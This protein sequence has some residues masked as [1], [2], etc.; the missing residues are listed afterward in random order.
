MKQEKVLEIFEEITKIP[1]ESGKEEQIIAYLCKWAEEHSLKSKVDEVG[2]VLIEAPA[3]PG[4]EGADTIVLQSH[5]DMVCEKNPGVEHDFAKDPIKYIIKDGWMIAP[6]TTLGADCGIG[7]AAQMAA[8]IDKELKHGKLEALF[9][10]SEETGMDGANGLKEGFFSGKTLINLDSE[11]DGQL[12]IGC[13]GGIDTTAK[14]KYTTEPA[15]PD[16][17]K[18]EFRID[19]CQG[20]HSGDDIDKN[21]AN[22]VRV[23]ARFLYMLYAK[24]DVELYEIDGGNKVNAIARNAYAVVGFPARA[25]RSVVK[26][27]TEF[28]AAVKAEYAISDPAINGF[29]GEVGVKDMKSGKIV[30]S[31]KRAVN[32]DTAALLVYAL[33]AVAHG[34]LAMSESMPGLVETSTNLASVKMLPGNVIVV[35]TS[36]RSSVNSARQM[37][38]NQVEACFALAGAIVTH[39]DKY[40]GWNPNTNSPILKVTEASYRRLFNQ[41]PVVRAIHAG[42]ECGLFLEKYPYLDMI[43][44][45][46]TLR[47]VHA[48]GE[49]LELATVDRFVKLLQDVIETVAEETK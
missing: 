25:K 22:A 4:Y 29:M 16:Y 46:P 20:G 27:F 19:G 40:P 7:M 8:L 15:T 33:N 35:A 47:S 43:S 36:Q 34:V 23:L 26:M 1:R 30:G 39:H 37:A 18:C 13:A 45:G 5:S 44:F 6:D 12:F 49:R 42:L 10:K 17:I 32:R 3:T 38:A 28:I 9:T 21:R 11:D 48:P 2:N 24:Y 14:F 41:E 31:P